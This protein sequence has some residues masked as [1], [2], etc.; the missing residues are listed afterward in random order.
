M[1][2]RGEILEL[3]PVEDVEGDEVDFGMA[4][5]P[6]LGGGHVDNLAGAALD[7]HMSVLAKSGTL[8]RVGQGR[9][10]VGR[11]ER[12]LVLL[13]VQKSSGTAITER[14]RPSSRN[15]RR[16]QWSGAL[17]W[18]R[19]GIAR[20]GTYSIFGSHIAAMVW[21]ANEWAS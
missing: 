2:G 12:D 17:A 16:A 1:G 3:L 15:E 9:A 10:G 13:R 21:M 6:G 11:L 14:R 5:L 4:V 18:G 7:D 8:L 20:V 19:A